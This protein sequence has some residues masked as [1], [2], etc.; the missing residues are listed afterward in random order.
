V[1]N[2]AEVE[3]MDGV[4]KVIIL[5]KGIAAVVVADNTWNA[6]NA[7]LAMDFEETGNSTLSSEEIDQQAEEVIANKIIATPFEKGD[8]ATILNKET[9][10][11]EGK[12]DVPYLAHA[13]MEPI[14]CT[15][16]IDGEKGTAWVGH[17]GSSIVMDGINAGAG[18][19]KENI[20]VHSKYLGGGFGRRAEVDMVV[21]AAYVA[22]QMVGTPV[23]LVYTREEAMRHEMYRP[24]VKSHFRAKLGEGGKIEAWEN[25]FA[26]QSVGY[27]SLM[28]IK[29]QFAEPP[30]NDKSS[31]EGTILPYEMD[32]VL[33]A[34][35]QV[36]TPVQVGNWRSVGNSQNGFFTESFIDECA[37]AAQ[38]DPYEYRRKLLT[39]HPR[40]AAVLDKVAEMS[41]WKTP[42]GENRFRGIALHK[43]FGSIVGQ[44][45]EITKINDKEFSIDK[46]YCV[47][48]CGRIV[49]PDTI[50]AQMQSGIMYGLT[51]ALYGKITFRDGEVEQYNFPQYEIVRMD[52]APVVEVHIMKVDEYPGGVGEPATPPAAP[53]LTN[54]VFAATGVRVRS[55]PLVGHGFRFV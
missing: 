52:V 46:Y 17:Q 13:C 45:A 38:V 30:A 4:K 5:P 21:N 49:N 35:G 48:D 2:Q 25:K 16:L 41:D 27:S 51:A 14:N 28:R 19:E 47:I 34:F 7:S 42:L 24:A 31:W 53:A 40:F 39:K 36:E 32:N 37:A 33:V 12:Y 10:I 22:K 3:A 23:Q 15:V 43:S 26:L 55:L 44:V 1:T 20:T 9:T 6:K 18:I 8:A 11:I 54:A 50:E 29:P